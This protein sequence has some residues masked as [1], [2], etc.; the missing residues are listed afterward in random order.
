MRIPAPI[1]TVLL[2]CVLGFSDQN[3][4]LIASPRVLLLCMLLFWLR[5]EWCMRIRVEAMCLKVEAAT[6]FRQ[7]CR[8]VKENFEL[9]QTVMNLSEQHELLCAI[10]STVLKSLR[11]SRD[12]FAEM[13]FPSAT[14]RSFSSLSSAVSTPGSNV[15]ESLQQVSPLMKAVDTNQ[16]LHSKTIFRRGS[17]SETSIVGERRV[18]VCRST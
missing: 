2:C 11:Y 14:N 16:V 9:S 18:S 13:R 10:R 15:G 17:M 5:C 8:L 4:A 6:S 12:T 7:E 3:I 1:F